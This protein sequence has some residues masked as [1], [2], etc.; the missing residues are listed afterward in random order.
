MPLVGG[1]EFAQDTGNDDD[2]RGYPELSERGEIN[3]LILERAILQF[4]PFDFSI[5][6]AKEKIANVDDRYE[7]EDLHG[8]VLG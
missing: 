4:P 7:G 8:R 5:S 6:F 2:F 3:G 1:I